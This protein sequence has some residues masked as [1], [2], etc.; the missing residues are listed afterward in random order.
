M[1]SCALS[2]SDAFT[3]P[4]DAG[5]LSRTSSTTRET[6][7]IAPRPRTQC[8]PLHPARAVPRLAMRFPGKEYVASLAM[9]RCSNPASPCGELRFCAECGVGDREGR[10]SKQSKAARERPW[11]KRGADPLREDQAW[12]ERH[13]SEQQLSATRFAAPSFLVCGTGTH[14]R[15]RCLAPGSVNS[16]RRSK[17]I[18]L[19]SV[20]FRSFDLLTF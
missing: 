3:P 20:D 15:P 4:G 16:T 10:W 11:T 18:R 9:V 12:S 8:E 19:F 14:G 2:R 1:S 7:S 6:A 5:L 17:A 13:G